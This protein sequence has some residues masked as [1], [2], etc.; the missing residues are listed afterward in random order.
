MARTSEYHKARQKAT[1][2]CKRE[3]N[4]WGRSVNSTASELREKMWDRFPAVTDYTM[5]RE[6]ADRIDIDLEAKLVYAFL[7]NFPAGVYATLSEVGGMCGLT[8]SATARGAYDLELVGLLKYIPGKKELKDGKW[9]VHRAFF[10]VVKP[11]R[12]KIKKAT[13]MFTATDIS[14]LEEIIRER[15]NAA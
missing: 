15:F 2:G 4:V 11:P 8:T 3:K 6:V 14:D 12:R 10:K 13:P 7:N 5:P 9:R 1:E